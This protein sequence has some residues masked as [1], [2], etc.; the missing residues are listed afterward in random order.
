VGGYGSGT[1]G[2]EGV[3]LLKLKGFVD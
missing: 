3:G 1:C 2:R